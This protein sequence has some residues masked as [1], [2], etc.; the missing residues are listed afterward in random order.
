MGASNPHRN[1]EAV[2]G[3]GARAQDMTIGIDRL[4]ADLGL[5][6]DQGSRTRFRPKNDEEFRGPPQG[7]GGWEPVES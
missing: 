4:A 2:A 3:G 6:R 5:E 7:A 1:G